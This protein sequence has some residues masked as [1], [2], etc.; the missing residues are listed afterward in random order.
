M[1]DVFQQT[2]TVETVPEELE[3]VQDVLEM[4]MAAAHFDADSIIQ[5]T[6]A[7]EEVFVNICHYAGVDSADIEILVDGDEARITFTDTGIEYNPLS[8]PEPDVEAEGRERK[9]GGLGIFMVKKLM[10]SLDY[11]REGSQN[12]LTMTKRREAAW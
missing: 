9:P 8:V 10:N 7:A 6:L 3:T 11:R 1:S 4:A 5:A 2:L 12:V